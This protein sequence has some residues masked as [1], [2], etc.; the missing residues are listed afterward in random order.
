[1]MIN[2]YKYIYIYIFYRYEKVANQK[3]DKPRNKLKN[4]VEML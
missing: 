1:M 3:A 4:F 2:T